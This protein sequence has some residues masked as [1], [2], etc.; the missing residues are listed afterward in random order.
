M[1]EEEQ[2]VLAARQTTARHTRSL[3]LDAIGL[4]ALLGL[5]GGIMAMLLFTSGVTR[6]ARL[7]KGNALRLASGQPLLPRP[8][9]SDDLGRLSDD[10][11]RLGDDRAAVL[12]R[13]R[14]EESQ[15]AN[16][17]VRQREATLQAVIAASPD[18]ITLLAPDGRVTFL[19][20]WATASACGRSC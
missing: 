6:R 7:L 2:R 15:C 16:A 14:E 19:S 4:S 1:Q 9:G 5:A 17:A 20:P 12:L 8:Y 13:E 3:A 18:V 11:G 10:L